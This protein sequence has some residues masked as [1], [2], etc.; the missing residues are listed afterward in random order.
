MHDGGHSPP[1]GD[2]NHTARSAVLQQQ[3]RSAAGDLGP[4]V[5]PVAGRR[6]AHARSLEAEGFGESLLQSHEALDGVGHGDGHDADPAR[7]GE[8][9]RD[10]GPRVARTFGYLRLPELLL[11]VQTGDLQQQRR[12][13]SSQIC[14]HVFILEARN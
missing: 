8:H 14:A 6:L 2:R 11:P 1:V 3:G 5:G 13:I 4:D 9:A 7:L 12:A 10:R